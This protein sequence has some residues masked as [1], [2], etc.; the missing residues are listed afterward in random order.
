LDQFELESPEQYRA[1]LAKLLIKAQEQ[2]DENIV[3]NP[4]LQIKAIIKMSFNE[5]LPIRPSLQRR[6]SHTKL[7]SVG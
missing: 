5:S 2:D 4:Y 6:T 7:S 1:I 3:S